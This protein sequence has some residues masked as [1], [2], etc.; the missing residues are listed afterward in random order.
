MRTTRWAPAITSSLLL[1]LS[2]LPAGAQEKKEDPPAPADQSLRVPAREAP[3]QHAASVNPDKHRPV[4]GR[5]PVALNW[6]HAC[7][8]GKHWPGVPL[9]R[10]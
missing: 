7:N 6:A 1:L 9:C 5:E 10:S 8:K 3:V 2:A 4:T